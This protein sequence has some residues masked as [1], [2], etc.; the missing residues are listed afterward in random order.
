MSNSQ[1]VVRSHSVT[2][3]LFTSLHCILTRRGPQNH[4]E[5]VA[6]LSCAEVLSALRVLVDGTHV[7]FISV[8]LC[9]NSAVCGRLSANFLLLVMKFLVA[10]IRVLE[11]SSIFSVGIFTF[12]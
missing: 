6:S 1:Q 4:G 10:V 11:V 7:Q 5:I 3:D 12:G 9:G 8:I 2:R